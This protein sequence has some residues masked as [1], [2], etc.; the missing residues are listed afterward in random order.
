MIWLGGA[1]TT[2]AFAFFALRRLRRYLHIYQQ[3]EYDSLRF[4]SWLFRRFAFDTRVA[5]AIAAITLIVTLAGAMPP[6]VWQGALAG[7]FILAAGLEAD[8]RKSAKKKLAMTKRAQR[9]Y[10]SGFVLTAVVAGLAAFAPAPLWWLV[11]LWAVPFTLV[12]GN[13]LMMPLESR[14]QRKFWTEAHTKLKRL[15]PMVIG[16]TGSFGKTSVK[17]ILGHILSMHART[18]YTPGSVN[19][20]MGNTRIIREQLKPGVRYFIAEMGAYGIGSIKRLCDLTPPDF[21]ILTTIGEA[22]YERFKSLETVAQA[23]FELS[24]AVI[25]KDGKMIVGEEVL[26]QQYAVDYMNA[27]RNNFVICGKGEFADLKI[28]QLEQVKDGL[29]VKVAWP[30][31]FGDEEFALFAPLYGLHHGANMALAF[32]AAVMAGVPAKKAVAA[33][34]TVPQIEHRLEVKPQ[35]DGSI[36]IDDAYNSN[37]SGFAAALELTDKLRNGCGRRILITPG[38]AELGERHAEAHA[39][40]GLKAAQCID[41]ALVVR[42]DRIPTFVDTF[43]RRAVNGRL[44][45]L[46]SF[47]EAETWLKRNVKEDDVVLI[48]N[49]LPDILEREFRV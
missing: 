35:G 12:L 45:K 2:V 44:I 10:W 26:A 25:A 24:E 9:I 37:P 13:I 42:S 4:L 47:A 5:L 49:D 38:M 23:K 20:V 22:H 8:P 39:E 30:E 1:V 6:A 27:H 36:L 32:G 7:L 48:E 43:E 28:L 33:M 17:H 14:T 19:T 3:E 46:R 11:P 31:M 15:R 40:L 29:K 21:G 16:I 18:L 34:A 41:V